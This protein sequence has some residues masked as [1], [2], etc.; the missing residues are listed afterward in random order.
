MKKNTE[1]YDLIYEIYKND[2]IVLDFLIPHA[3]SVAKFAVKIAKKFK[4]ADMDFIYRASLLHDIGVFMTDATKI[5]CRGAAP[6]IQHGIFGKVLLE[7]YGFV[8][9]ASVALTHVGAGITAQ[10]I[11]DNDLPLPPINMAPK[12][13]EEEIISYVDLFFSKHP[14]RLTTPKTVEEVFSDVKRYGDDS[15]AILESWH[16]R[17]G[18]IGNS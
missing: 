6:Y 4:D 16:K 10:H 13:L 3:E 14:D 1:I 9:E 17:F 7:N 15:F 5:G 8:R 2:E 18:V 11:L 12:T